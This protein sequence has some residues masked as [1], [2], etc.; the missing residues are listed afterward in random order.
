MPEAFERFE[1]TGTYEAVVKAGVEVHQHCPVAA[2]TV[3]AGKSSVLTSS[4]KLYYYLAGSAYGTIQ[5]CLRASGV[6]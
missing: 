4:G 2:L 5:D 3:R 1:Q 6:A